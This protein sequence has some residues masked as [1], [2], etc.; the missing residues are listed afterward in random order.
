MAEPAQTPPTDTQ[1][2]RDVFDASPIGIAVETMRQSAE[3][4]RL[5][6][7]AGKMF[8]YQW[9]V[10]TDVVVRSG[11]VANVLGPT[12]DAPLTRQQIL[13]RIHPDDRARFAASVT[14]R[15]P[16]NPNVQ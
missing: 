1:L 3:R 14:E 10:A 6:G 8:A 2:F 13:D 12:S 11:D 4:F 7:Q 5:A 15:T 9:D 16:E